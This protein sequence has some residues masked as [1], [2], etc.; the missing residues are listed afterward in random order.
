MIP[1]LTAATALFCANAKALKHCAFLLERIIVASTAA[2]L[3][4]EV[5]VVAIIGVRFFGVNP[6]LRVRFVI[7]SNIAR[8]TRRKARSSAVAGEVAFLEDLN[9]LMLTMALHRAG[10]TNASR[11]PRVTE[12]LGWRCTCQACENVLA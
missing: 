1:V 12:S 11:S 5:L 7:R 9:Q 2:K 8:A 3:I 6:T 10:I 4:F